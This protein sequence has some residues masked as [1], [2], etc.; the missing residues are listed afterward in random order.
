ML[1]RHLAFGKFQSRALSTRAST[2][3]SSLDI[4]TTGEIPGVYNG[5]WEGS[6]DVLTS[7]C[8]ATGE[9]LARVVSASPKELHGTLEQTRRAYREFRSK[10]ADTNLWGRAEDFHRYT[11]SAT[12]RTHEA[13]KRSPFG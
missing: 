9:V 1:R 13:N 11:C 6:G 10:F 4:P 8:P 5:S 12:W 2:I 7:T 3:L